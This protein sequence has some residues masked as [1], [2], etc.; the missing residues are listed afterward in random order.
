MRLSFPVSK[1]RLLGLD[2]LIGLKCHEGK[3]LKLRVCPFSCL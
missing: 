1:I 3:I 2:D